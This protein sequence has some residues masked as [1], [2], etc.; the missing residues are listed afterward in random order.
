MRKYRGEAI[1]PGGSQGT[2]APPSGSS[3]YLNR[4]ALGID[5]G[6]SSIKAVEVE[7]SPG[8]IA[9]TSASCVA[10]PE[11]A[12][13]DGVVEDVPAIAGTIRQLT[14]RGRFSAVSANIGIGGS[15]VILRWIE[16]PQIGEDDLQEAA[17]LEARRYLPFSPDEAVIY[18]VRLQDTQRDGAQRTRVLLIA[19]RRTMVESRAQALERAGLE[20]LAMDIEPFAI[21]RAFSASIGGAGLFWRDQPV[22]FIVV[23]SSTINMHVAQEFE[24]KFSRS[25]PFSGSKLAESIEQSLCTF[26]SLRADGEHGE[27]EP[28]QA[29]AVEPEE[30]E[31]LRRLTREIGRLLAYYQSLFPERSYE[32]LLDKV[33]LTGG[34]A[35]LKGIDAY[36]SENL[37][38]KI[39]LGN[40]FNQIPTKISAFEFESIRSQG[41]AYA[42]AMGLALRDVTHG[43]TGAVAA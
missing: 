15:S 3:S 16:L 10:T 43:S 11:G 22:A 19:A 27:G 12:I 4:H 35:A 7:N 20:P 39:E 40:P 38:R 33:I 37:G 30:G 28:Q 41:P 17:R 8:G 2:V 32:G 13:R 25:I 5:I 18:A 29:H 21:Q 24:L 34:G 23:G 14:R 1:F 36:L 26:D 9:I 42:A 6:S 31:E